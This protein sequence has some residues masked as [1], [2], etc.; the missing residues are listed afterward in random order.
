MRLSNGLRRRTL[1]SGRHERTLYWY[2]CDLLRCAGPIAGCVFA[3]RRYCGYQSLVCAFA[4]FALCAEEQVK[5]PNKK[6][7]KKEKEE[8]TKM[9]VLGKKEA[10]PS[11]IKS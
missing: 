11:V 4:Y 5:N 1:P 6:T 9:I 3:V 8:Q 2:V 7:A 10:F